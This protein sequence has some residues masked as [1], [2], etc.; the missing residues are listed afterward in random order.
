MLLDEVDREL[1][2]RGH[3]FAR[4]ADDCNIYVR[5]RKAG[6][7]VMALLQRLYDKLRL[8]INVSKSAVASAFGRKFLGYSLWAAPK[9]EVRRKVSQKAF[10]QRIR[11]LPRRSGGRSMTELVEPLRRY[12]LGWKAYFGLAQAGRVDASPFA[13]HPAQA[14]EA[15]HNDVSG[16]AGLGASGK[17]ALLV[18]KNSHRWWRDSQLALNN[19]LT[20]AYFDR[21]GIPRLS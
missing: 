8:T 10:K 13:G 9:G 15:W 4:Y 2:R 18:A 16:A 3:R 1:E 20:I 14:L 6:E 11:A 7:R 21:L 5:S 17:V 19:V 12:V